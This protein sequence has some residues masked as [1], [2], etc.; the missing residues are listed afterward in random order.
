MADIADILAEF[1]VNIAKS[2]LEFVW[3][4]R[5]ILD[6]AGGGACSS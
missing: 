6:P 4:W 5:F 3:W 2:P 1:I